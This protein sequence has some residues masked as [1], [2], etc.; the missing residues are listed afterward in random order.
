MG[1][2]F[3]IVQHFPF[4]NFFFTISGCIQYDI[5]YLGSPLNKVMPKMVGIGGSRIPEKKGDNNYGM[6]ENARACQALCQETPKCEWFNWQKNK[7][8]FLKTSMGNESRDEPGGATGPG[9]CVG[10]LIRQNSSKIR[11][12]I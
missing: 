6:T 3:N 8:C 12:L 4:F 2:I 10:K 1:C 11:N 9:F 5:I 7:G